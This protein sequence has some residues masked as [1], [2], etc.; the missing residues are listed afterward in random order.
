MGGLHG[1]LGKAGN[2]SRKHGAHI[3][4]RVNEVG[5]FAVSI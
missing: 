4:V 1:E 2:T 5:A 3:L